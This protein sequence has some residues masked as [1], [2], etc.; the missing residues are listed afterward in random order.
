[1]ENRQVEIFEKKLDS[2]VNE[3]VQV[4]TLITDKPA[5]FNNSKSKNI[6]PLALPLDQNCD[7]NYYLQRLVLLLASNNTFHVEKDFIRWQLAQTYQTLNKALMSNSISTQAKHSITIL[8][9]T[10]ENNKTI[11]NPIHSMPKGKIAIIALDI[12]KDD[13]PND[14]YYNKMFAEQKIDAII[15]AIREIC[16]QMSSKEDESMWIVVWR[17]YGLYNLGSRYVSTETKKYLK[18][19]MEM[20]CK[21]Y[22][23]LTVLAGTIATKKFFEAAK[24]HAK[25]EKL[26]SYYSVLEQTF[27][28]NKPKFH[29]HKNAVEQSAKHLDQGIFVARNTLYVFQTIE[30][31]F[32]CK[33][34]DKTYPS[35]EINETAKDNIPFLFQPGKGRN[36][37]TRIKL[38][39]P[40]TGESFYITT[41][42]CVEHVAKAGQHEYTPSSLH[43]LVSDS[44]VI[45]PNLIVA[46][47]MVHLDSNEQSS[48]TTSLSGSLISHGI[49]FYK[50]DLFSMVFNDFTNK[51]RTILSSVINENKFNTKVESLLTSLK[52]KFER[53]LAS[54]LVVEAFFNLREHM[55]YIQSKILSITTNH[56]DDDISAISKAYKILEILITK[57]DEKLR[58]DDKNVDLTEDLEELMNISICSIK[59]QNL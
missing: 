10:I 49:T 21:D 54:G 31:R 12:L 32:V 17:E 56:H 2:L 7:V 22:P 11:Q 1:M 25:A 19:S 37:S 13:G 48:V 58:A 24:S 30:Q 34:H 27:T 20:L 26:K 44:M 33:R 55:K 29:L 52:N 59:K 53:D 5:D 16:K 41:E 46:P 42:I 50:Y 57:I 43:F 36:V 51:L 45:D 28:G 39:H 35:E 18:S 40:V 38:V 47:V 3:V 15:K 6:Y 14:A 8:K 9:S 23:K 4:F